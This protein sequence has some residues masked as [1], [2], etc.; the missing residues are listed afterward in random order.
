M[1]NEVTGCRD[2]LL[3]L[4][5][6]PGDY[7]RPSGTTNGTDDP[8]PAVL[9]ASRAAG[10]AQVVG[11]DV[12]PADYQDPGAGAIVQRT[13]DALRPGSIVSLHFGHAGTIDA[14]PDVFSALDARG[15]RPVSV[16]Q[17]LSR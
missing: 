9:E 12:D 5:G 10:Y 15:L 17:L 16:H 7:F 1:V 6:Q 3:R 13:L 8:A 14:L 11:Y 2:V 4:A